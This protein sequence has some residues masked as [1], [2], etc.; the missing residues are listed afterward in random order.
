[1]GAWNAF[2]AMVENVLGNQRAEYYKEIGAEMSSAYY[3][4]RVSTYH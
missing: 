4:M 1:M 3:A 2:V